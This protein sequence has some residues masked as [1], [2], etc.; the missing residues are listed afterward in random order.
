MDPAA[1][2]QLLEVRAEDP[3]SPADVQRL[4]RAL[5]NP[6]AD[7]LLVQ[8]Q[9]PRHVRDGE[10]LIIEQAHATNLPSPNRATP[11]V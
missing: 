2:E 10:E 8:L 11:A 9:D 7:R 6:V 3:H 1:L 5:V 4:Q